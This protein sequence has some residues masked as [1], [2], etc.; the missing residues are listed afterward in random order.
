MNSYLILYK[1]HALPFSF[2]T[3]VNSSILCFYF[4]ER[5]WFALTHK[6]IYLFFPFVTDSNIL[7]N[8]IVLTTVV[9]QM[10]TFVGTTAIRKGKAGR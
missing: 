9:A 4:G 1:D 10:L 6:R 5:T 3:K 7:D 2:G 8:L